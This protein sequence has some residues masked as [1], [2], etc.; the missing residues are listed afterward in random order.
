[1]SFAFSFFDNDNESQLASAI[2]SRIGD[3]QAALPSVLPVVEHHVHDSIQQGSDIE[4][5]DIKIGEFQLKATQNRR[6]KEERIDKDSD[7]IKGIYEGGYKMWECSG[8]LSDYLLKHRDIIPH[9]RNFRTIELGCGHGIP[10]IVSL[11]MGSHCVVFSDL[12]AEVIKET[13]WPNIYLNCHD[14]LSRAT[15]YSGDWDPLS[16]HFKTNT[17]EACAFDLILS[18]ETLYTD[19]VC[20]KLFRFIQDHLASTG[21]ALVASKRFYFGVGGG[22][23]TLE[24][25]VK[26][27]G[28]FS[29][30]TVVVFE[31]GLSNIREI[32]KLCRILA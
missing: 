1:M 28:G 32:V 16:L 8:D 25:L 30:E 12:N 5:I 18:A 17:P 13:T 27:A 31:D 26:E 4:F 22:T 29:Y 24:S 23:F 11:L 19:E 10:G 21:C 2:S 6:L 7:I 20:Q 14:K 15:C 9:T 3:K